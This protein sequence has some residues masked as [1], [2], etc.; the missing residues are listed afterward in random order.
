MTHT[1]SPKP[2]KIGKMARIE[3]PCSSPPQAAACMPS[4]MK[5]RFDSTMPFGE[6]V[7]PPEKRIAAASS[8][9]PA[10]GPETESSFLISCDHHCT[11]GS[12]G[13]FAI[14]RPLVSQ[15]PNVFSG[16]R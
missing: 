16:E 4:A 14:L 2:W 5:L 12:A 10:V 15:K 8:G 1:P 11:R 9:D 13:T 6:P 7:V 3:S